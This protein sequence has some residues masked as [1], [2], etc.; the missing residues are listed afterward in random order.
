M[1]AKI[2]TLISSR[3]K[4]LVIVHYGGVALQYGNDLL[5]WS[6]RTGIFSDRRD[7]A[8]AIDAYY[9]SHDDKKIPLG[10]MGHLAT[11]SF[12]ETKNISCG[13]GGDAQW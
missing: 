7:A 2:Q 13:E 1:K 12:H 4:A 11:F 10:S 8:A 5:I 3:T 9:I 6:K